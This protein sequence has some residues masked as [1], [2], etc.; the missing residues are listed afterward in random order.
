VRFN[1]KVQ[2]RVY[3]RNASITGQKKRNQ[4][5]AADRARRS[6]TS[7]LDSSDKEDEQKVAFV[8]LQCSLSKVRI[9]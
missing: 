6:S 8:A 2:E 4:K 1:D 5:R 7:S 3:R 9:I